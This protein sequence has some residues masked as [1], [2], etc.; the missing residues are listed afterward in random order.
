MSTAKVGAMTSTSGSKL[1]IAH[2][3]DLH[4]GASYH[5]GDEDAGGVNFR[6]R[7][8]EAAGLSAVDAMIAADVRVCVIPGDIFDNPKPTPTEIAVFL[9]M[10]ER[11]QDADI[12]VVIT[13]G[14]HDSP[15][16]VGRRNAVE[17]FDD[18][19]FYES[20]R[21]NVLVV[22]RPEVLEVHGVAIACLPYPM[23]AHV[24][25]NDPEFAKLTID[26]QNDRIVE[27]SLKT[28]HMLGAEAEQKHARFGSLLMA[29]GA[30]SGS[31][32]AHTETRFF[33]EPVLPLSELQGFSFRCQCWGHL[34]MPQVLYP[35][36]AYSGSI[37][38]CDFSEGTHKHGWWLI[39]LDENSD[40]D[41][42]EFQEIETR[43]LVDIEIDPADIGI[44]LDVGEWM[45]A[46]TKSARRDDG[47]LTDIARTDV[48]DAIVRVRYS[49]TP[50]QRKTI[51][52]AAIKRALLAAGAV[53]VH[54][55][56]V[57]TIH[58]ITEHVNVVTEEADMHEA[59]K[60]WA[61][62]Q[63]VEEARFARLDEKVKK[64]MEVVNG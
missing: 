45:V 27:L 17:I 52:D 61:V 2:F 31:K 13:P 21:G 33:R 51:D 47:T 49:A 41:E 15:R 58:T 1:R 62:L 35:G 64:A 30:I 40:F 37:E 32:V 22:S 14:N 25:A 28:L 26:E 4:I 34:H 53:K 3:A 12:T 59:W 8:F 9:R 18:R 46:L 43:R 56:I 44:G 38:A 57:E 6:L 39:T 60:A 50:E 16:Q 24:A 19:E 29:H 48:T 36:I 5:L 11:L 42:M 20:G 54:G 63:G 10:L 55:P 23:R 7:D